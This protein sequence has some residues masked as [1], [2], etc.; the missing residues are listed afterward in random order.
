MIFY[1]VKEE[2]RIIDAVPFPKSAGFGTK[3]VEPLHAKFLN[4]LRSLFYVAGVK[5]KRCTNA[6]I[7]GRRK[8]I[9]VVGNPFFL[10]G[11]A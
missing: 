11:T 6:K 1:S 8:G 2:E 5:G 9:E 10:L 4:K 3:A 7:Y